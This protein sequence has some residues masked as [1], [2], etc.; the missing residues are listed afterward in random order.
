MPCGSASD[1]LQVQASEKAESLISAGMD[2][3]TAIAMATASI[4]KA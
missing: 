3:K 2:A 1:Y 4:V